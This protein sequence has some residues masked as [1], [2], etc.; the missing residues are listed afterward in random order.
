MST[1]TMQASQRTPQ[2][3]ISELCSTCAVQTDYIVELV[4][5]G[6]ITPATGSNPETWRFT[7]LHVRH[8]KVAWRL[9]R[10]LGV[11]LPGAALALQLMQELETL[12]AQQ[13]AAAGNGVVD[14]G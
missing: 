6:I 4:Q 9:Q 10:D 2:L 7:S 1:S 8:T 5:E 12:R 13:A 14:A 3:T 11:N